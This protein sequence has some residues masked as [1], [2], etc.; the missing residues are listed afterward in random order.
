M[1]GSVPSSTPRL[2]PELVHADW[3]AHPPGDT[4]R[5]YVLRPYA[6]V[7][8]PTGRAHSVT[9]LRWFLREAGLMGAWPLVARCQEYLGPG[10]TVWGIKRGAGGELGIEL[11]FYR[12][13][14]AVDPT[15]KT[16]T[17]LAAALSDW[18]TIDTTLDESLDYMMCSLELTAEVLEQG[19]SEGFRVYTSGTRSVHGYDGLS[20]LAT[21]RRL[22]RENVYHF[23]NAAEELDLVEAQLQNSVR[24]GGDLRLL[25][26]GLTDC[27]TICFAVKR[28]ADTLYFSRV[29]TRQARATLKSLWPPVSKLLSAHKHDFAH[30][31]WDVG[32]DFTAPASALGAPVIQK[33]GLYGYC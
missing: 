19:R 15:K 13:Q 12:D 27:Y 28:E 4:L 21:G 3:V 10:E 25:P 18:L 24:G 23:Y 6:P 30:L 33:V 8:D 1:A 26:R 17:A 9:L 5:D 16:A 2:S 20:Y 22:L 11:Y 14:G 32:Y 29:T 7:V 31:R